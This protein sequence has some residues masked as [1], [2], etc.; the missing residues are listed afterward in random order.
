MPVDEVEG[1]D[2]E[3]LYHLSRGSDL[4]ARGERGGRPGLAASGRRS[5]APGTRK[6][7]GLLGQACYRL[8]RYEEAADAY[9]RLVDDNPVEDGGPREPRA[10]LP[11]GA[12]GTPRR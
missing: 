6:V 8:G 10:R 12:G 5:S 9:G 11:E 2:E 1:L 7:L 4:L 3:F